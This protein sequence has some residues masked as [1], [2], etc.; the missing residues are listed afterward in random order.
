MPDEA[1]RHQ[2]ALLGGSALSAGRRALPRLHRPAATQHASAAIARRRSVPADS[3]LGSGASSSSL[4]VAA[5]S[6]A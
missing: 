6:R 1:A 2:R 4:R 5:P 3:R